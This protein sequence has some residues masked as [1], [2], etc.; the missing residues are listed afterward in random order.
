MSPTQASPAC[1]QLLWICKPLCNPPPS[2]FCLFHSPSYITVVCSPLCWTGFLCVCAWGRPRVSDAAFSSFFFFCNFCEHCTGCEILFF[3]TFFCH[4]PGSRTQSFWF[5]SSIFL[6]LFH[7][8]LRFCNFL[9]RSVYISSLSRDINKLDICSWISEILFLVMVICSWALIPCVSHIQSL[10]LCLV[11][12]ALPLVCLIYRFHVSQSWLLSV[13]FSHFQ[14]YFDSPLCPGVCI[15]FSFLSLV[16]QILFSCAPWLPDFLV[17]THC[18][19]FPQFPAT[20]LVLF[21]TVVIAAVVVYGFCPLCALCQSVSSVKVSSLVYS[22]GLHPALSV[23]CDTLDS[24][25]VCAIC[26]FPKTDTSRHDM[27]SQGRQEVR[28]EL[29]SNSPGT[30]VGRI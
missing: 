26:T 7:G 23:T 1:L 10:S 8:L 17:C 9:V 29:R 15:L 2:Q 18:F 27:K 3:F 25:L 14:F 4:G 20:L 11:C 21:V 24:F 16:S 13:I 30:E 5:S 19:C 12:G 6:L 22:A 28:P